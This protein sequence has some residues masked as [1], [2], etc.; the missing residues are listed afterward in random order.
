MSNKQTSNFD[1]W[2]YSI[3][4]STVIKQE[5]ERE[6]LKKCAKLASSFGGFFSVSKIKG[7]KEVDEVNNREKCFG[8]TFNNFL[9]FPNQAL[10]KNRFISFQFIQ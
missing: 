3:D 8:G 5:N 10:E 7:T 1:D 6:H 9:D 2:R 4:Y